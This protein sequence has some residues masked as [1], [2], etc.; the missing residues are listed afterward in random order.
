MD[1]QAADIPGV[2]FWVESS[3]QSGSVT[4]VAKA[5]VTLTADIDNIE[6]W[7]EV[8]RR[9]NG[10]RVFSIDDF[11]QQMMAVLR[12][13]NQ[14]LKERVSLAE[15]TARNSKI[16]ADQATELIG[17]R[18]EEMSQQNAQLLKANKTLYD[19]I[20]QKDD[21]LRQLRQTLDQLGLDLG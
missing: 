4:H 3:E 13:E 11:N 18:Y 6:I 20:R 10:F 8:K 5:R 1:D 2:T 17:Q 9:L 15:T 7:E 19:D 16:E 14:D 21:Q 12:R